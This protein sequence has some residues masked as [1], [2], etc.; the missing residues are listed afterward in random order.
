LEI[1]PKEERKQKDR[2]KDK[3]KSIGLLT[4]LTMTVLFGG[5]EDAS[6]EKL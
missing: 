2:E 5:I 3:Q 1:D 4:H 6:K